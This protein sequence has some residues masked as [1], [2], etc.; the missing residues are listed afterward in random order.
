MF[1]RVDKK[2]KGSMHHFGHGF[3]VMVIVWMFT[4]TTFCQ[5]TNV[6]L[7]NGLSLKE[8]R[9][10]VQSDGTWGTVC[11]ENWDYNDALVVCRSL[12]FTGALGT[13]SLS[14]FGPSDGTMHSYD[15]RCNGTE[16]NIME[17]LRNISESNTQCGSSFR[18]AGVR[19][20]DCKNFYP[21]CTWRAGAG[22][23]G[24]SSGEVIPV[25]QASCHQCKIISMND[26][27]LF[28]PQ[29]E[30]CVAGHCYLDSDNVSRC[31][32]V[33]DICL[34]VGWYHGII[35]ITTPIRPIPSSIRCMTFNERAHTKVPIP[36]VISALN[37][38]ISGLLFTTAAV[39]FAVEKLYGPRDLQLLPQH[40]Y[41][42]QRQATALVLLGNELQHI[43]DNA[44]TLFTSLRTLYLSSNSIQ[45]LQRGVFSGLRSLHSLFLSDNKIQGIEVGAFEGLQNLF[46]LNLS[47]NSIQHLERGVFSGLQSLFHLILYDNKIRGIEVGAFDG[48]HNLINLVLQSNNISWIQ[49]GAF[50]HLESLLILTLID[51]KIRD[52]E[53]GVFDGLHNLQ[54]LNLSSNSIQ[55]LERG[56]FSDLRSLQYLDLMNNNIQ[57]ME[58]FTFESLKSLQYLFFHDSKLGAIDRNALAGLTSVKK[59]STSDNRLCCLLHD[60]VNFT[61]AR[62]AQTSQLDTCSRL[63]PN[64]ALRIAGWVMGLLALGGN[65]VV[66]F[67]RLRDRTKQTSKVQN[68]MIGSLAM[69]DIMMGLYMIII[70][71]ADVYYG[72]EFYLSA[73]QWRDSHMCRFAGFLGF[74]SSEAS[75]LTLTLITVD[76][77]ISIM[78]PFGKL[79]I[80]HKGSLILV[81]AVWSFTIVLSL[82]LVIATSDRS[83]VLYG[84][85]DVCLG[86]PLHVEAQS[87]GM[88]VVSGS[89]WLSEL[90]VNYVTTNISSKAPWLFSI[91]IFIGLNLV[92]F[93][94]ILVCYILIFIKASRSSAKVRNSQSN[95]QETKLA[96]RMALLVATDLACW[97]PVIIMGILSQTGAVKLDPSLYAWTVILIVPINSS[98]NPFL[99]TFI[100]YI[101]GRKERTSKDSQVNLPHCKK[102]FVHCAGDQTNAVETNLLSTVTDNKTKDPISR[103]QGRGV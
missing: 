71:S 85:S 98:I 53:V 61:C 1:I 90:K 41:D 88:L 35:C 64:W 89:A 46:T 16:S 91:I 67:V 27:A 97:M 57:R 52:I 17:C 23:C 14:E 66:L 26:S 42:R 15:F 29:N 72:D 68:T 36:E 96:F 20:S 31:I 56:V 22:A 48:L 63:Y 58:G 75:V 49:V 55:H 69:A 25:C 6:R 103:L 76:R 45:H 11:D 77:F 74:L 78:F 28:L 33:V 19:C 101:D 47:S 38:T 51:N 2:N 62:T 86:L 87:T 21:Y 50:S 82:G 84:L 54:V 3:S 32:P 94:F 73:P 39:D 93:A 65:G 13:T 34:A 5:E 99:Y 18:E 4:R 60:N 40:I 70:T 95:K 92:S 80:Q 9:V 100:M 10:E 24:S 12:G 37:D 81:G 30:T 79:K 59:M 83:D 7:V 44:F 102:E 8:G 43:E